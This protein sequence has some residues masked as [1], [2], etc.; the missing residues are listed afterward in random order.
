MR[1]VDVFGEAG[2]TE[3]KGEVVCP[4]PRFPDLIRHGMISIGRLRQ[5][6]L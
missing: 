1:C 3:S 2:Q 6:M 4:G 5:L